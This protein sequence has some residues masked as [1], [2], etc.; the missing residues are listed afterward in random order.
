MIRVPSR[1][2]RTDTLF[3]YPTLFRSSH[4]R[5]VDQLRLQWRRTPL[6]WIELLDVVHQVQPDRL[7]G[8]GIEGG[9]HP[10]F[11]VGWQNIDLLETRLACQ[12]GPG[13]GAFPELGRASGTERGWQ[14]V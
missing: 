4:A 5:L 10:R 13:F 7:G 14:S 6:G 11:A 2:T 9:D 12:T 1:S 3:P 8:A